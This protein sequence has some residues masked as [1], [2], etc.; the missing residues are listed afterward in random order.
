MW[1]VRLRWAWR[2]VPWTPLLAAAA[3]RRKRA[4][5]ARR[6]K[7]TPDDYPLGADANMGTLGESPLETSIV[8]IL[9]LSVAGPLLWVIA[10]VLIVAP[11]V[12]FPGWGRWLVHHWGEVAAAVGVLLVAV[13]VA[14]AGRPWVVEA[15]PMALNKP[16]RAW[17]VRDWR[18]AVRCAREVA[19]SIEEG[20]LDVEP[21]DAVPVEQR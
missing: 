18:R 4:R 1:F 10:V 2:W 21:R 16:G 9:V 15:E 17:R 7:G 12:W 20:R 11:I 14:L 6:R 8:A 13:G 5:Q 19:A 3:A